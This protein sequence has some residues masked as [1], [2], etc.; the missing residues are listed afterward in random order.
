MFDRSTLDFA[1]QYGRPVCLALEAAR[2][3]GEV[4]L[5]FWQGSDS[6][7]VEEKGKGDLVTRADIESEKAI[8][9]FLRNET[10]EWSIVAEEG[11]QRTAGDTVWFVDPL[12]GTTNFVQ[13]L[14]LFAVSIGLAKRLANGT[15]DLLAGAVWNPVSQEIFWGAKGCGSYR[16]IERL[17]VSEKRELGDAVI[18]TGFPRRFADELPTYL[19]EFAALYLQCRAI[20]RPGAASLDLCWTAQKVYDA[21]WEHRLSPW[22]IAAGCLIVMEAGGICSDLLGE[23]SYMKTGNI[24]AA[25]PALHQQIVEILHPLQS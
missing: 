22:D 19:K 6:N 18:G 3:G 2:R 17:C 25:P 14:P 11:T 24:L 23:M 13:R 21:F 10:P 8:S 5:R 12:D 1:Q 4:L 16:G 20:R 9:D 7:R 15:F